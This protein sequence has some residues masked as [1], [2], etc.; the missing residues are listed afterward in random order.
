[1]NSSTTSKIK[2]KNVPKKSKKSKKPKKPKMTLGGN[3][4]YYPKTKSYCFVA[5]ID[6]IFKQK[7]KPRKYLG[8]DLNK[9]PE[10]WIVF[11]DKSIIPMPETIK[12]KVQSI[13]MVVDN[14]AL[15]SKKVSERTHT[16][17]HKETGEV[18]NVQQRSKKTT[19][20]RQDGSEVNNVRE[21][22]PKHNR[23]KSRRSVRKAWKK[24]HQQLK[25]QV[26]IVAQEIIK[27]TEKSKSVLCIDSV[28][29]G[30]QTGTYAQDYL[31]PEL[32]KLC[33][34]K[35]IPYY[36]IP[37]AYTSRTCNKCGHEEKDNRKTTEDFECLK[38]GH[39]EISHI[40][41]AENIRDA[42]EELRK[43]KLPYGDYSKRIIRPTKII[44]PKESEQVATTII[45]AELSE[46]NTG[47]NQNDMPAGAVREIEQH[48]RI[49][50]EKTLI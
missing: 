48:R 50:K 16:H 40:N 43:K 30:Q 11:S 31:I 42:G 46:I 37:C 24:L 5:A 33:Q 49:K 2:R 44:D 18:F 9:T 15:K 39:K 17:I 12:N 13:E 3:L 29:G 34:N 28:K 14:L 6:V 20:F 27:K 45:K 10:H 36:V 47:S 21:V 41:A 38:C 32:I 26:A 25:S 1:M 4:T 8:F 22:F 23:P 19:V 35:G 7:Y